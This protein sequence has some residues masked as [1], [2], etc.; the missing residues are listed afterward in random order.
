MQINKHNVK[1]I[2]EVT[3]ANYELGEWG[4]SNL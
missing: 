4:S 3:L 2:L 1:D